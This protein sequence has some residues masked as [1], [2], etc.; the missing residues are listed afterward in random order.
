MDPVPIHEGLSEDDPRVQRALADLQRRILAVHPTATFA[1][2]PGDEPPGIYLT[3]TIDADEFDDVLDAV[4]PRLVDVQVDEGL[5]VYLA[6]EQPLERVLT[7]RR[8]GTAEM[9]S[10]RPELVAG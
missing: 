8:R 2:G 7:P 3:A 6:L 5:P 9:A 1:V 4:I 10:N